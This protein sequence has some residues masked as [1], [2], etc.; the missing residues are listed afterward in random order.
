MAI[1]LQGDAR[2]IA[3]QIGDPYLQAT[4]ALYLARVHLAGGDPRSAVALF[5][6]AIGVADATGDT[7]PGVQARS[8]LA[9]AQLQAGTPAAALSLT[10]AARQMNYP[11]EQATLWL[12]EG[13]ALLA[14]GRAGARDAFGQALQAADTLL[15]LA[16]ANVAALDARALACCGLVLTGDPARA[17]QAA[18][19][20]A[21]A[22]TVT[23][24]AGVVAEVAA[25]F[26]VLASGDHADALAPYRD[27]LQ[28]VLG[29]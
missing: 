18:Q 10:G 29:H 24:A 5:E 4:T 21:R 27:G 17:A 19:T 12:L 8:G 28:Q 11:T 15:A 20:F 1:Q 16:D 2:L 3:S 6:E 22:R 23:S 26:A 14:M 9:R 25:L 13:I 7:E